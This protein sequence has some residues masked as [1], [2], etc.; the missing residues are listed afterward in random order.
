MDVLE[1][2]GV[3]GRRDAVPQRRRPD[4]GPR[5]PAPGVDR[6]VLGDLGGDEHGGGR[7]DRDRGLRGR[8]RPRPAERLG[9]RQPGEVLGCPGQV[10]PARRRGQEVEEGLEQRR[11]AGPLLEPADDERD[12]RLDEDPCQG[13]QLGIEDAVADQLDDRAARRRHPI[14]EPRERVVHAGD[15]AMR[16]AFDPATSRRRP[17]AA[18]HVVYAGP[19]DRP[20]RRS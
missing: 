20:V 11:L 7:R 1:P 19:H 12:T 5:R 6:Q 18:D 2:V 10:D 15:D 13:R 14:L 4:Q 16:T 8:A 17:S 3:E 9:L